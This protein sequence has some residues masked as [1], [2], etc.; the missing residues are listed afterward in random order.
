[1]NSIVM[2]LTA[3]CAISPAADDPMRA[4]RDGPPAER[5]QR[6]DLDGTPSLPALPSPNAATLLADLLASEVEAIRKRETS[7]ARAALAL[8]AS[9]A[10]RMMA[11]ELLA[12]GDSATPPDHAVVLA[13]FRLADARVEFDAAATRALDGGP[14][15]EAARAALERLRDGALGSLRASAPADLLPTIHAVLTGLDPVLEAAG[16]KP[17]A[18][19]WPPRPMLEGL[20]A[21]GAPPTP[22][23]PT[24]VDPAAT[25]LLPLATSMPGEAVRS[26]IGAGEIDP[27][28][29]EALTSVAAQ[30]DAAA[31]WPD[32]ALEVAPIAW[33]LA[34]VPRQARSIASADWLP[35]SL[36]TALADRLLQAVASCGNAST[37]TPAMIEIAHLAALSRTL[38]ATAPLVRPR[39]QTSQR[40]PIDPTRLARAIAA[41]AAPV[42]AAGG[43]NAA[44]LATATARLSM[45]TD[46]LQTMVEVRRLEEVEV[47]RELRQLRKQIVRDALTSEEPALRR[48]ETLAAPDASPS[49][50]AAVS[51]LASQQR[52]LR[53]I[54]TL[55]EVDRAIAVAAARSI[56]E[57]PAFSNRL[58]TL[59]GQFVDPSRADAA[60]ARIE[61]FLSQ[62]R[63][64]DE[65]AI[66][67]SIRAG[68]RSALDRCAGRDGELLAELDRRR[69]AWA[70]GWSEGEPDDSWRRANE[71]LQLLAMIDDAAALA[72]TSADPRLIGRWGGW[73]DLGGVPGSTDAMD[74]R[75]AVAIEAMARGDE[76]AL[77]DAMRVI[78]REAPLWRLRA[79]LLRRMAPALI[80]LP[81]GVTG[82][83]GRA[84]G[85]PPPGAY[86]GTRS[87]DLAALARA[88]RELLAAQAQRDEE[89][90]DA[91][92]R[93]LR[94]MSA[95][96]RRELDHRHATRP[97][98]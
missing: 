17:L 67:R 72:R 15:S 90:I 12:R 80:S 91:L 39:K 56:S 74:G 40:G 3:V 43:D 24:P 33:T 38:D 61:T 37:R 66:E 19:H 95:D 21:P 22:T 85:T 48:V 47:A 6:L 63:A 42:V 11:R 41:L 83:L 75:L 10:L 97:R 87:A 53:M 54:S 70:A 34:A 25:P 64:L 94:E 5:T 62:W 60:L 28:L 84:A 76:R 82:T 20:G 79:G 32:L 16:L 88:A 86:M 73:D 46:L 59:L 69:R 9:M 44:A 93:F 36:R 92:E 31:A 18:N 26:E 35:A 14:R 78:D 27:T 65:P 2:L 50:P 57:G 55:D 1:M 13:G 8:D 81:T 49:D 68:D 7:D 23:V 29:A 89:R 77:G 58:R 51:L 71:L 45:I 52:R 98:P 96:L 4:P 30:L